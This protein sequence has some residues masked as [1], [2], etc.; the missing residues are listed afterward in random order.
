MFFLVLFIAVWY[1]HWKNKLE[2]AKWL[3][4]TA[5]LSIPLGYLATELGWVVAEMGRQP[6]AIQDIMPV[7]A[8]ISG[9]STTSVQI[10]SFLFMVL[11]T[12]LLIAEI[13]IMVKQIQKGPGEHSSN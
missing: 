1:M 5:L 13:K 12:I 10:T 2:N 4:W 8:A 11:F 7:Q 6:W 9:I 3:L